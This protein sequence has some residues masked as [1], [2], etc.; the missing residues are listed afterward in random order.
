MSNNMI[1]QKI[2]LNT[3]G[4]YNIERHFVTNDKPKIYIYIYLGTI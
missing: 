4:D 3:R 1:K 2:K